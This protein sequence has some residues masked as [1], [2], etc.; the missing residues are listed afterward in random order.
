[1]ARKKFTTP[2]VVKEG[3]ITFFYDDSNGSCF[4]NYPDS[5]RWVRNVDLQ[6]LMD[7]LGITREKNLNFALRR[8][9]GHGAIGRIKA[10]CDKH[11]IKHE[12]SVE[13]DW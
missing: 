13:Y 1:M 10:F 7:A 4:G 11:N 8:L 6:E 9:S 2:Y 3:K 5:T 12:Y